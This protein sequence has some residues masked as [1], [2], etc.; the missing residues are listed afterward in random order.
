MN[1]PTI[2]SI[3]TKT[4]G[5]T[6]S[7]MYSIFISAP[8]RFYRRTGILRNDGKFEITLDQRK[9]KSPKGSPFI[10]E[11]EP[12]ALAVAAEWDAQKDKIQRGTMHLVRLLS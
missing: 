7:K 10:I 6:T 3:N 12:L 9:L 1:I 4:M 5:H 11:S 2:L 8:K